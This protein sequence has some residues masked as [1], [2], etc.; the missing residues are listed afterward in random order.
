MPFYY[1][2]DDTGLRITLMPTDPVTAAEMIKILDRQL[3]DGALG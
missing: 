3:P 1:M 2:R